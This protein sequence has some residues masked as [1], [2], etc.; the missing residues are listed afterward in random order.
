MYYFD[1]ITYT[2]K[3]K[4]IEYTLVEKY[5]AVFG[6]NGNQSHIV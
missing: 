4:L 6:L 2:I 5:I 1:I 3:L